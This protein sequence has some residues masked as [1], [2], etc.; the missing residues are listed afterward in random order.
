MLLLRGMDDEVRCFFDAI[1]IFCVKCTKFHFS[2]LKENQTRDCI[3][4]QG[5]KP[6]FSQYLA[7]TF[8]QHLRIFELYSHRFYLAF[9]S[10]LAQ[11]HSCGCKDLH[12]VGLM[13]PM[14]L[15]L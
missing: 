11:S 2:E 3:C 1:L 5:S 10:V 6:F 9:F 15:K 14:S 7:L 13:L 8:S 4:A 12:H